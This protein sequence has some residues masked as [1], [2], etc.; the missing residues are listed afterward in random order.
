V[1]A[2]ST[3]A[4]T[5]TIVSLEFDHALADAL[6]SIQLAATYGMPVT[7]F[8]MSGRLDLTGYLTA[9][10]LRFVQALGDEIGGHTIDH[11][12]LSQLPVAAQRHEICDDRTALEADGLQVTDFAYPYG[13]AGPAT[14]GIVRACGYESAR[15]AGRLAS[16]GGCYGPCPQAE[17]V[18]P[19]DP[20]MTR[21]KNSIL[22][23]TR[24][25]TLEA[26]VAGPEAHGGGWVQ[27]VFHHVCDRSTPM[28]SRPRSWP[29]SSPGWPRNCGSG[30]GPRR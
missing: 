12:D 27:I 20:F 13:H 23:T 29:S 9:D 1:K 28:R 14:P 7:L 30:P 8:A 24:L 5:R 18:P 21:A 17:A 10:Q 2:R 15:G 26:D 6:P 3:S 4:P 22:D 16:A 19:K 11:P 25:A